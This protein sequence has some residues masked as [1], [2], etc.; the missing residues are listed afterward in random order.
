MFSKSDPVV[1]VFEHTEPSKDY[2]LRGTTEMVKNNLN[3]DFKTTIKLNYSFE[4]HQKLKFQVLDDDGNNSYEL[5]GEVETHMGT[6]MGSK[7]QTFVSELNAPSGKS[8]K[9]G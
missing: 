1:K 3:P 4:K 5:I 8:G 7:G 6:V 2:V 9:R